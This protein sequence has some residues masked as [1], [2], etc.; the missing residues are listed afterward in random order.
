MTKQDQNQ[1]DFLTE[2]GTSLYQAKKYLQAADCFSRAAEEHDASGE[3]L[4]AAEMRNNQS[5]SLLMA[6]KPRLALEAVV[7]TSTLFRE[8]GKLTETGM[9]LANEATALKELGDKEKALE[10]FT[11]AA[12]CFQSANQED[13]YLQ[14]MQSVSGLKFQSR[15]MIGALFS[16]QEGLERLEKPTW[17]QKLLKNLLKIPDNLLNK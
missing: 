5:V 4:L 3:S 10:I 1:A 6:K 12:E 17:R 2:E 15:N 9:A 11:Q 7:G 13:L 16:M 8:A 14:T